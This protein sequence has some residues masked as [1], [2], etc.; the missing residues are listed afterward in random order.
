[1][2][3]LHTSDWHL[4]HTL[5]GL[6][7]DYEHARF[8]SWLLDT[9]EAE[10]IDALIVAG[11]VFDTANPSAQAQALWYGFLA[12]AKRRLPQL[13]IVVIAGNHDSA[14]R[15]DAPEPLF[16]VF[17]VR[18][19]GGRPADPEGLL[20]PLRNRGGDVAA[21]AVAVP[22]LRPADL[23]EVPDGE[24]DPLVE[25]VRRVYADALGAAR[26]RRGPGQALVAVGHCYLV[27][28]A[29]SELSERKI[30][31]GN[32]HPL[33]P[34]LF[35]GDVAYAALGHLH[36][37]QAVGG[38]EEVRY[39]GSPLPLSFAEWRYPHQVVV[40]ELRGERVESLRSVP[41]PRFVPVLRVPTA[42]PRPLDEVLPLLEGLEALEV[43]TPEEERPYLEVL[44]SLPRPEPG[45]RRRVEEALAGKGARL[46]K[47][48]AHFTGH[49]G[50]LA[51]ATP[52]RDLAELTPQEVFVS[53]CRRSHGEP[54]TPELLAAFHDLLEQAEG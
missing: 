12:A 49:G 32:Q 24:S 5:H 26:D 19:V 23:A 27:G 33:P 35:P 51:D 3:L 17:G 6:P 43:G 8:L 28:T 52:A 37:A 36:L 29:L 9:L 21:W 46:L 25:G 1:M 2:R 16:R 53:L 44:V 18:V 13:D 4:G 20:V 40:A 41:V 54:P 11:D 31:G 38:R 15:L 45:L 39:S 7:R 42:G 30:L 14:G 34:D 50:A 47:L 48:T 22:F 10:A